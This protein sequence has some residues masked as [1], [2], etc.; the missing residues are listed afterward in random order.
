MTQPVPIKFTR[1][2]DGTQE[3][4][5]Y[6]EELERSLDH[7]MTPHLI[8]LLKGIDRNTGYPV[9]TLTHSLQS[10]TRALRDNAGEELVVAALFHDIGDVIAPNNHG[11]VGAEILRPFISERTY[12]VL[13]HHAIFQGHYFWHHI[14]KDRAAREK[15]RGHPHFEACAEFCERWDQNSFDPNYDTLG[16]DV[17]VPMV[18]R[19]LGRTPFS[20]GT[21]L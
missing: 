11:A 5:A 2:E 1:L 15:Y 3:E 9:S 17:F 21:T 4:F 7:D 13:R 10:A 19:V 12:W 16:L 18:G 20:Q 8:A 14:G 6:L